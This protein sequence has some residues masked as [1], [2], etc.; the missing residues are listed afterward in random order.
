MKDNMKRLISAVLAAAITFTVLTACSPEQLIRRLTGKEERYA[1]KEAEATRQQSYLEGLTTAPDEMT[2]W[3]YQALQNDEERRVYSLLDVTVG[4]GQEDGFRIENHMLDRLSGIIEM[5]K[6]DHPEVFWIDDRY[7]YEY[8]TYASYTDVNIL[9]S[10]KPSE[11]APARQRLEEAVTSFL[12]AIPENLSPYETELAINDRLLSLC[13]YDEEAAAQEEVV[14]NE[15]T[16]YGALVDNRA[17]CEGYTR[18]FQLLCQRRGIECLPVNGVSEGDGVGDGNHIWNAVMLDGEWYYVDVTWN[19]FHPDSD[20]YQ[21]TDIESHLYFNITT[22]ALLEDHIIN[23]V[24]GSDEETDY[25]N[26]FV[27]DCTDETY[28]YF[29]Q[30][31]PRLSDLNDCDDFVSALAAAAANGDETFAFSISEAL[32]YND[33]TAEIIGGYAYEWFS[34][35]NDVNDSDHQLTEDCKVY[36]YDKRSVAAFGLVYE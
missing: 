35:C 6:T 22:D 8:T 15:Q 14:A 13:E 24:F 16:A 26:A 36:T 28:N 32:D 7:S 29:N 34:Y 25:Y 10:V 23:P 20:D 31:V 11:I 18:A 3:G 21:L 9:Y 12:S 1:V 30:S 5:Y 19:D 33:T 2:L 27:P 17:V 4:G